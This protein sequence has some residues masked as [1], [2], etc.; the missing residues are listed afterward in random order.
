MIENHTQRRLAGRMS[1][2]CLVLLLG[3]VML[4]SCYHNSPQASEALLPLSKEQVDSLHFYSKHHYTN[5]YNFIVKSDSLVLFKQQPE[6][7]VSGF[8]IDTLVLKRHSHVVVADIRMLP[9][10]T[11]DSVWVQLASDQH[12]FGWIHESDML[13]RVVPDDP[14][15]Q[16]I[17]T[18]SDTHLLIFLV[19]IALIAIAY[20]MH[21]L[22]RDNARI[23]HFRDI[24]SF[25][26]TLLC[27]IV[28]SSATL[29]ASIQMYAPDAWRHFYYHP[30]L[31]P[32]S[33][34]FLLMVFLLSVW[35]MLI[36]GLAAADDV[37]HQL[38]LGDAV[39]YLS[40]LL[41]MC[42]INYIV[43]SLSTLYY[44]GYPLLI[45]YYCFALHR[46]F[47]HAH[48]QYICGNCGETI[49]HKGR[50]PHCGAMNA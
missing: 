13:P 7:V 1:V 18:F 11:V 41:A 5:N 33:V 22:V 44:I 6:E 19:V 37:R 36:V 26:P 4:T 2:W 40:G 34:P 3:T 10:D 39:M 17:S 38:P 48:P 49:Q 31:N 15:S 47:R 21:R 8:M 43:F 16:F 14:I 50:C 28:A 45:G 35:A 42:A 32:F 20:W 29:Y 12:T 30:T 24:N 27:L 23:V 46:Y 9:T 25:Y